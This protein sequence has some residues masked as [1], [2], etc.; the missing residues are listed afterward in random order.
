ML[1]LRVQHPGFVSVVSFKLAPGGL[2]GVYQSGSLLLERI[3][4]RLCQFSNIPYSEIVSILHQCL[5]YFSILHD[6]Y[7]LFLIRNTMV[8]FSRDGTLKIWHNTDFWQPKPEK[9][10]CSSTAEMIRQIINC[11]EYA[12]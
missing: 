5:K 8:G 6:S 3:P 4:Y 1:D 11:I 9:P 10:Y 2:C 7:G 12:G